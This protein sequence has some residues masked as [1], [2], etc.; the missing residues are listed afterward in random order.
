MSYH[1]FRNTS[2][3]QYEDIVT[4][5]HVLERLLEPTVDAA[6]A[7]AGLRPDGHLL[8]QVPEPRA[9][10]IDLYVIDHRSRLVVAVPPTAGARVADRRREA[11]TVVTLPFSPV[12]SS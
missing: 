2:I 10:A 11:G 3:A 7:V 4:M 8:I 1:D 9:Q 5:A 6:P 12:M